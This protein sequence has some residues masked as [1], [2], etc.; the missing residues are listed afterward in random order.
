MALILSIETSTSVCS[1]ALHDSGNLVG[2]VE[3]HQDNV[4][5]QK[6]MLLIEDLMNRS[7]FKSENLKAVAVS[8]GPGSYTGLRIGVSVAKGFAFAHD[9]PLIA[10]D[11]LLALAKRVVPLVNSSGKIVPML[12]AR[13]MEVYTAVY[14]YQLN[15]IEKLSPRVI[16][17]GNPF[18]DYLNQGQ[19][20]FLGDGVEKLRS[21]LEHPSSVLL[22]WGPSALTLGEL[23]FD[24]Y[25]REEFED[26][27]YFEPNYLKDFRVISS[28]KNLLLS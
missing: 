19:V 18:L 24:K 21:L 17:E 28:K 20:Y 8:S 6:L 27:A 26:L 10:V 12:D 23:A 16:E 4:H 3:L 1:L 14:D 7:G 25:Q 11:T 2:V 22:K 15:T 9:I 13:R 5:S